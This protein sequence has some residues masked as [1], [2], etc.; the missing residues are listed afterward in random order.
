MAGGI[1]V[2]YYRAI[3]PGDVLTATRTLSN[4]YAR[5]GGSGTLVFIEVQMVVTDASGTPVLKELTTRI[6]R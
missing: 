2:E 6:M 5:Q 3:R 4:I 1:K